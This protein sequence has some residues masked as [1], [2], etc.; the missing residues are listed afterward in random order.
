VKD[1]A[2]DLISTLQTLKPDEIA[3]AEIELFP[4]LAASLQFGTWKWD[5]ELGL[6]EGKPYQN[7]VLFGF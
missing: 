4:F 7:R 6:I 5:P 2:A 1:C 3:R